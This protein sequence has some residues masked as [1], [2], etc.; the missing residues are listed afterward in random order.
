MVNPNAMMNKYMKLRTN[1]DEFGSYHP[2]DLLTTINAFSPD[3]DKIQTSTKF[4][5]NMVFPNTLLSDNILPSIGLFN[6]YML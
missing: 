3:K 5:I 1:I 6:L 2:N 4:A